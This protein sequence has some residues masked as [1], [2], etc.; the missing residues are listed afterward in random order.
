MKEMYLEC[1]ACFTDPNSKAL[2]DAGI[3]SAADDWGPVTI[4]IN[5]IKA[6]NET[7]KEYPNCSCI[8]ISGNENAGMIINVSYIDL[9]RVIEDYTQTKIV[10]ISTKQHV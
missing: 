7:E 6:F 9:K 5:S 3:E 10:K 2:I 8:R 1:M 4:K